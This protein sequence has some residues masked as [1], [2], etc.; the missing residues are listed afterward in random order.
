[1]P[2]VGIIDFYG[3]KRL[4]RGHL[5]PA[6]GVQIGD[7]LPAGPAHLRD[8]LLQL[9]GVVDA[10]VS[11]VCCEAGRSI[12]YVG[13]RERDDS[14]LVFRAAPTGSEQLPADL[15]ASGSRYFQALMAGIRQG[16]S[17]ENDSAGHSIA[18]YPP[19]RF[20]QLGFIAF[21]QD[22]VDL[23][24]AVLRNS[25]NAQQ[26]A[27]AAQVMAYAA[28]KRSIVPDLVAAI[29]DPNEEVRNNAMRALAVMAMYE[30]AHP[31]SGLNVPYTP[32]IDMLSSVEWTDRNKSSFALAALTTSRDAT[33]LAELRARALG[34][35]IEMTRWRAE[36]HAMAAAVILGRIAGMRDEETFETFRTNREALIGAA[37]RE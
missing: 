13:I 23:L 17:Q 16:I 18:E 29:R 25:S 27:L 37:S 26:R 24:R 21:A 15:V 8:R 9:P 34:P 14:A 6:L 19:A 30:Q 1:M 4:T 31:E 32:F 5:V 10:D 2:R 3:L 28:D 7:S 12:M 33:L 35:L 36:G 11:V 20:E 22:N